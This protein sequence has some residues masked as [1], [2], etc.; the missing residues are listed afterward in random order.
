[1]LAVAQ[2]HPRVLKTP[3]PAA[4]LLEFA[5]SGMNL[6]LGFWIQDPEAGSLSVRSELNVALLE[7]FRAQGIEIPYPRRDV[8]LLQGSG[9]A[10]QGNSASP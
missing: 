3:E 4:L 9:P 2:A 10:T 8:M 6:E 5:D 1:M 7:K